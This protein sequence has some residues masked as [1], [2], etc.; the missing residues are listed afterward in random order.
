[1]EINHEVK[2]NPAPGNAIV[3]THEDRITTVDFFDASRAKSALMVA[4]MIS[5][6]S[7]IPEAYQ[8]RPE[9]VLVAL[10]R[11]ARLGVDPFSCMET[12][13]VVKGKVGHE[14]KFIIALLNTC[15]KFKGP[16]RYDFE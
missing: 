12:T 5:T 1:M 2:E 13:Y 8:R 6:S 3:S 9:N 10:M 7:M 11:S 4:T 16:I 15:G 14:A